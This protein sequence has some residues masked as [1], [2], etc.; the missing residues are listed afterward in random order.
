MPRIS[1][2]SSPAGARQEPQDQQPDVG[3]AGAEAGASTSRSKTRAVPS[4]QPPGSRKSIDQRYNVICDPLSATRCINNPLFSNEGVTV[5]PANRPEVEQATTQPDG[6]LLLNDLPQE[7]LNKV[8]LKLRGR[9]PHRISADLKHFA[10]A[11]KRFSGVAQTALEPELAQMKRFREVVQVA[12]G[13]DP[14][15]RL[16]DLPLESAGPFLKYLRTDEAQQYVNDIMQAEAPKADQLLDRYGSRA[17]Q[18]L[19]TRYVPMLVAGLNSSASSERKAE[20][21]MCAAKRMDALGP[22]DRQIVLDNVVA[23]WRRSDRDSGFRMAAQRGLYEQAEHLSRSQLQELLEQSK[24]S[25]NDGLWD[26][27]NVSPS[28]MARLLACDQEHEVIKSINRNESFNSDNQKWMSFNMM[29]QGVAHLEAQHACLPFVP[30]LLPALATDSE[31]LVKPRALE[32]LRLLKKGDYSRIARD[33]ALS[34]QLNAEQFSELL[35]ASH[36]KLLA[37]SNLPSH[38]ITESELRQFVE[39]ALQCSESAMPCALMGLA[40][41]AGKLSAQDRERLLAA[42]LSLESDASKAMA[43]EAF[44]PAVDVLSHEQMARLL[45]AVGGFADFRCTLR[46]VEALAQCQQP[47]DS[48]HFKNRL[49]SLAVGVPEGDSHREFSRAMAVKAVASHQPELGQTNLDKLFQSATK[50]QDFRVPPRSVNMAVAL[51]G[52][53][54]KMEALSDDQKER[55]R[56]KVF[57]RLSSLMVMSL[58]VKEVV[59]FLLLD[60]ERERFLTALKGL[61]PIEKTAAFEQLSKHLSCLEGQQ[62]NE[63]LA[64]S[65]SNIGAMAAMAARIEQPTIEQLELMVQATC[66]ADAT[67]HAEGVA[68]AVGALLGH[69]ANLQG[70][71]P[72]AGAWLNQLR[73]KTSEM[74]ATHHSHQMLSRMHDVIESHLCRQSSPQVT[75]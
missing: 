33:D 13:E 66:Q 65:S 58:G 52:V 17:L 74:K 4:G 54:P 29:M 59:Q 47:V 42:T 39:A 72:Q 56:Q 71:V 38:V 11:S 5:Q 2:S 6:E 26:F 70:E 30:K 31:F 9:N 35:A 1:R 61:R 75:P 67:A 22:Q 62:L 50:F 45:D 3:R 24:K 69:V 44:A 41:V 19:P 64:I 36:A 40:C 63:L 20:W 23:G 55:L 25:G 16:S 53:L 7:V 32:L 51:S 48:E 57:D 46:A 49:V 10:Q 60:S 73:A 18:G 34:A 14:I 28:A 37:E 68:K 8:A 43:I 15:K 12:F 21:L 27:I